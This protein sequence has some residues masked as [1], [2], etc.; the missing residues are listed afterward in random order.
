MKKVIVSN[1][2]AMDAIARAK[3]QEEALEL[4]KDRF[5]DNAAFDV[6]FWFAF[7][8]LPAGE[9]DFFTFAEAE[10]AI[11]KIRQQKKGVEK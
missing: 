9:E 1:E 3:T 6:K 7:Y 2:D 11:K 5:G 8:D 4:L 10:N